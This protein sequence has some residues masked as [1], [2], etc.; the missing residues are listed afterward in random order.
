[1]SFTALLKGLY[2]YKLALRFSMCLRVQFQEGRVW[3]GNACLGSDKHVRLRAV[4]YPVI[5]RLVPSKREIEAQHGRL[6]CMLIANVTFF[7]L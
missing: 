2:F 6:C 7:R 4:S 1:V 3:K 5:F